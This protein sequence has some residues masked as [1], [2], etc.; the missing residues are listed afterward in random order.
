MLLLTDGAPNCNDNATCSVDDCSA[1][2]EGLCPAGDNCCAAGYPGGGPALCVDRQATVDA[3]AAIAALGV[4]VYVIGIPGSELYG[5]VLDE[6]AVAG[7][8]AQQGSPQYYR[9]D[10]LDAV[11]TTFRQI[12]AANISCRIDL[13][14]PPQMTGFTNV[15][16]DCDTVPYDP[17]DGWDWYEGGS[18]FLHG[19]ACA[20]LRSGEV[21]QVKVATGCPTEL[22]E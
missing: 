13:Q 3:V 10:D 14:D 22:P 20:R 1:N 6:M 4:D 2:I 9:V 18:I 8:T 17:I 7:G 15:Y 5:G 16:F 12:A 11:E 19:D 21:I